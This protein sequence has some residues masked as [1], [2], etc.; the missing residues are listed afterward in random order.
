MLFGLQL[1]LEQAISACSAL[2]VKYTSNHLIHIRGAHT[3]HMVSK[4]SFRF[5]QPHNN[6]VMYFYLYK[7]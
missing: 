6:N 4:D 1:T 7:F 2:C 3:L 5:V